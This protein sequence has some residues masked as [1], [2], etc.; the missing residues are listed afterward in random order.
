MPTLHEQ[1][2]AL[3]NEENAE[4]IDELIKSA[5][6]L[7]NSNKQL[8][9]RAKKAEGFEQDKEGNWVKKE[10]EIKPA[11]KPEPNQSGESDNAK[12]LKISQMAL[13]T[14][15]G[16][17]NQEQ[18]DYIFKQV[19]KYKID[20]SEI[21]NDE[22]HQHKLKSIAE[23]AEVKNGMPNGGGKGSGHAANSVDYWLARGETP[24]D[25]ELA[26]KVIEARIK[27]EGNKKMFSD[28]LYIG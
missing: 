11:T 13:L 25:Q 14:A 10:S 16:Y 27:K 26:E 28:Q 3:K 2:Q 24:D 20:I 8:F 15:L 6:E 22:F 23:N 4:Q 7:H 9:S 21:V 17:K 12:T 5:N 19:D 18:Q 1:L